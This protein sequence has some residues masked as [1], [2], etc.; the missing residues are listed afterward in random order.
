MPSAFIS[1]IRGYPAVLLAEQPAYKLEANLIDF[2]GRRVVLFAE[3][4][5]DLA[6]EDETDDVKSYYLNMIDTLDKED[7]EY[8]SKFVGEFKNNDKPQQPKDNEETEDID[9]SKPWVE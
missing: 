3:Y 2:D 5:N 9:E 6:T 8:T 7:G 1:S 4:K